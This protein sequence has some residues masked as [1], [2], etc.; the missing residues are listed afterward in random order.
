ME[1]LGEVTFFE[2]DFITSRLYVCTDIYGTII[3]IEE[4]VKNPKRCK[5]EGGIGRRERSDD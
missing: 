3:T 1:F 4:E 5:W 2:H